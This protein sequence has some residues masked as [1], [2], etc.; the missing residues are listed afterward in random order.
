MPL[1]RF[2]LAARL[3][4]LA[5]WTEHG[6]SSS[7]ERHCVCVVS[8]QVSQL[9]HLSVVSPSRCE[10]LASAMTAPSNIVLCKMLH[11]PGM[12]DGL[13]TCMADA[14]CW[15]TPYFAS[16]S[17][18]CIA[19]TTQSL[20]CIGLC[21]ILWDCCSMIAIM[22]GASHTLQRALRST[23]A[24]LVSW[25]VARTCWLATAAADLVLSPTAAA[26]ALVFAVT[27]VDRSFYWLYFMQDTD[28]QE[29][30]KQWLAH[31]LSSAQPCQLCRDAKSE[32]LLDLK[33]LICAF[34]IQKLIKPEL[35]DFKICG[36]P[37]RHRGFI[38][39]PGTNKWGALP[40][41]SRHAKSNAVKHW[42]LETHHRLVDRSPDV[43]KT[44]MEGVSLMCFPGAGMCREARVYASR[45]QLHPV[46]RKGKDC[47]T[48]RHLS[49]GGR[50]FL[51]TWSMS[52]IIEKGTC[53]QDGPSN[54]NLP[55]AILPRAGDRAHY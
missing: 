13:P 26:V 44:C 28:Q 54:S 7:N 49:S 3:A 16:R 43:G 22:P 15:E 2:L 1:A 38:E 12:E 48:W 20:L 25:R 35:Q 31:L 32:L 4:S 23:D 17:F 21:G 52:E 40:R 55:Y 51:R 50:S 30:T 5:A 46:S 39:T 19:M 37:A 36:V 34:G 11:R 53:T 47:R 29:L 45:H 6:F 33:D 8:Q 10:Y 18:I 14:A 41:H 42:G 9:A 27:C 24:N